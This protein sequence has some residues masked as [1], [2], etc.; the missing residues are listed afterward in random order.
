MN[1]CFICTK[2]IEDDF[3]NLICERRKVCSECSNSFKIRNDKFYIDNIEGRV[4]YYYNDFFKEILFRYKGIGDYLLK[5]VFFNFYLEKLKKKYREYAIVIA[6]SN[7][8]NDKKR[9]FSH[10]E[11]ICKCLNLKIIKCF[12]K[13][14]EWKQSDKKLS[15]RRE[16]QNIIKIDIGMLKGVKKVLIVDDVLTSGSTIKTMISQI[17]SNIHK[18]VLVLSSNCRILRNEIV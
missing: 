2:V 16:I 3:V 8:S 7:E 4:L 15:E 5:D 17:P 1:R 10:M 12:K 9:G 13:E 11:E 6:P 18:K 14:K